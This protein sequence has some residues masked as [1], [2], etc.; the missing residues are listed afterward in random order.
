[1]TTEASD[2]DAVGP[3]ELPASPALPEGNPSTAQTEPA[4]GVAT[5]VSGLTLLVE[6]L[7]AF[8]LVTVTPDQKVYVLAFVGLIAPMLVGFITRGKV[9]SPATVKLLLDHHQQV[10]QRTT[11]Q[12]IAARA[13][14]GAVQAVAAAMQALVPA[15]TPPPEPAQPPASAQPVTQPW[16]PEYDQYEPAQAPPPVETERAVPR[17]MPVYPPREYYYGPPPPAEQVY[18]QQAYG[19]QQGYG[20]GPS[21]W[22]PPEQ[23]NR[24]AEAEPRQAETRQ[25]DPRQGDP[26]NP[27]RHAAGNQ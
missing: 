1:M 5:V 9:F 25:F 21:G 27:G 16:L 23:K 6:G 2:S 18:G 3:P 22:E 26:R 17:Q 12:L 14:N 4:I 7:I 24:S 13:E 10:Q 15:P 19:Q 20:H 8:G 11:A